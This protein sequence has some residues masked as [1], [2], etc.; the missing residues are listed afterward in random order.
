MF[1]KVK[2]RRS[3]VLTLL[4][5]CLPL[6]CGGADDEGCFGDSAEAKEKRRCNLENNLIYATEQGNQSLPC[7]TVTAD[8][9]AEAVRK[10]TAAEFALGAGILAGSFSGRG[11]VEPPTELGKN[12]PKWYKLCPT[13][14]VPDPNNRL[15]SN[16]PCPNCT[17]GYKSGNLC[18][19]CGGRGYPPCTTCGDSLVVPYYKYCS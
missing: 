1:V 3:G 2:P 7:D 9:A 12:D 10:L 8:Q 18:V 4:L 14:S 11:P 16:R 6:I 13:C 17:S 15:Q 5:C 19:D